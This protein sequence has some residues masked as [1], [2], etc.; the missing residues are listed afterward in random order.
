MNLDQLL[1][2]GEQIREVREWLLNGSGILVITQEQTGCGVS[3]MT[4]LLL[5]SLSDKVHGVDVVDHGASRLSVTGQKKVLIL[6]PF[7][8]YLMDQT[9]S[10]KIP[11]LVTNPKIPTLISGFKRRVTFSK[12][13]DMLKKSNA[14][15]TRLCMRAIPDESAV[16]Y[17]KSIGCTAPKEAWTDSGRDLRHAVLSLRA[18]HVKEQLP[19][20]I[21]ALRT[22]LEGNCQRSYAEVVRVIEHDPTIMLDG[23]YENYINASTDIHTLSDA[24]DTICA[25]EIFASRRYA[26]TC[27]DM[28]PELYG[29]LAGLAYSGLRLT[30]RIETFG[31]FWARENHRHSK[32][33]TLRKV[34]FSGA[35]SEELP[36]IR[37]MLYAD[38]E[39]QAPRF[40]QMY[41]EKILWDITRLWSQSARAEKYTASRHAAFLQSDHS[42][43]HRKKK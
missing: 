28:Q 29:T 3:T 8:T 4:R 15:I 36:F 14:P 41:G 24:M 39:T 32:K 23:L 2:D 42:P 1:L 33:N 26:G 40:A 12:L 17:L 25:A 31:T 10:K 43:K 19:D 37:N 16:E 18:S 22:I 13:D 35:G 34:G 7:E 9:A 20:G 5:E 30:K 11:E 27:T 6:D 38:P 21:D